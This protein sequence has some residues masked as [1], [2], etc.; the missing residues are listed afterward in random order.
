MNEVQFDLFV[1]ILKQQMMMGAM[2]SELCDEIDRRVEYAAHQ[3]KSF[4]ATL[5]GDLQKAV[6]EQILA[7]K[8][9][10]K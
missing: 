4:M 5:E 1:A 7:I 10:S 6:R 3:T 9:Q 2:R 8:E